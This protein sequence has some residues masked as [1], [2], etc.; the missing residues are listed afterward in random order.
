[1]SSKLNN[2]TTLW[3][4]EFLPK[5]QEIFNNT[6]DTWID[7]EYINIY[8]DCAKKVEIA[9]LNYKKQHNKLFYYFFYIKVK[10]CNTKC[11]DT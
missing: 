7:H 3:E 9:K 1:M 8:T 10:I 11:D 6:K 2:G 4:E 5:Y